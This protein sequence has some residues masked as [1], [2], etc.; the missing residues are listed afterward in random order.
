[1]K[2]G[3]MQS[4]M[5]GRSTIWVFGDQLNRSIGALAS[6]QPDHSSIL[7]IESQE[8]LNRRAWHQQRAHLI[9]ASMRRF[10][11]ALE[12]EGFTVDYRRA[13]SYREGVADHI[14]TFSPSSV[15]AMAPSSH[16]GRQ[17]VS[18]LGITLVDDDRFLTTPADFEALFGAKKR[19]TMETFYRW[20]RRRLG[21]LM[22]GEEPA[23]GRWNY[24]EDNR[25][26]LPKQGVTF[27]EPITD[28]LDDLD[29]E[30]IAQLPS[31]VV[32][33]APVGLWPT[34]RSSALARLDHVIKNVLP[35]FGP[36][37]DAMTTKS[38]HLAHS[39]LSPALN[40]GLLHPR[41]VADAI[42]TAYRSGSVPIASAE[43]LLRQII[44]WRE[45]VWCIYWTQGP[46]YSKR[47]E[48][49]ANRP[50][51]PLFRSGQTQMNCVSQVL[52]DIDTYGWTHHI[53]RLM[54]LGN[55]GLL[56]GV[57]PRELMD[58]MWERFLDAAE[59][60]MAPNVI[61]MALY[62][63]GG[64]MATKPY[65]A[66]GAYI[67]KM[68]DFCKGCVFDR[69]ARTGPD[70]CPFTTLYWDFIDRHSDQLK[71]NHRMSR[72]VAAMGNLNDLGDLRLRATQI[73]ARLDNG[74]L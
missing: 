8:H 1:M 41:E 11:T 6:A 67:D 69:K 29:G 32:G 12:R 25:Q 4:A 71:K 34:S 63:D 73:L 19:Y 45:F 74:D 24:D 56:S 61:G 10:A 23:T 16:S 49:S 44:G 22:D 17:F 55:L 14:A 53:P 60:V 64:V 43:G 48:L 62:A 5:T 39:M 21:Y 70:A 36:Y 38:W 30:V 46:E 20:Q 27:P 68:S 50:L 26:A 37:E 15:T 52:S 66:G 47:N 57:S 31:T 72:Q 65:A 58:W 40:L 2:S 54:V 51:P 9:I 18:S 3:A 28:E 59:W 7:F 42:E 13:A 33:S 35:V